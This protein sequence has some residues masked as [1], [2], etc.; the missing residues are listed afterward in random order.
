MSVWILHN[1]LPS[2]ALGL[3]FWAILILQTLSLA[4]GSF[5]IHMRTFKSLN[6]VQKAGKRYYSSRELLPQY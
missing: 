1:D 4:E 2:L 6:G 3:R 5:T